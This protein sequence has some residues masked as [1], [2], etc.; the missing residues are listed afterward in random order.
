MKK[1]DKELEGEQQRGVVKAISP[2]PASQ[3]AREPKIEADP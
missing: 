3:P 2:R 1:K